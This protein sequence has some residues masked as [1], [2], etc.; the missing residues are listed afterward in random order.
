MRKKMMVSIA[1]LLAAA[2]AAASFGM[3]FVRDDTGGD[4]LWNAS[5]AYFFIGVSTRGLHVRWLGYPWFFAKQLMGDSPLS[6]FRMTTVD[7]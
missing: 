7:P 2:V 5:E 3:Y 1:V 6:N 4:V